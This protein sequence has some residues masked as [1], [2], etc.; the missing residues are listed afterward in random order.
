VEAD[1]LGSIRTAIQDN[2]QQSN[3][4]VS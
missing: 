4:L 2:L 3:T 1:L